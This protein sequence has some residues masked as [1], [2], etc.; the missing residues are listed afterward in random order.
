[1]PLNIKNPEV[2]R[3]AGELAVLTGESKTEVVR[4]ALLER[5][6]RLQLSGRRRQRTLAQALASLDR[7]IWSTF[8]S[9]LL[10]RPPLSRD[11]EDRILGYGPEGV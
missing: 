4:Q 6:A 2:E 3:L 8:P 10:G 9:E 7:A 1:M 11:E 5:K